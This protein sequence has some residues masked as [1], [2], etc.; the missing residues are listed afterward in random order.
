MVTSMANDVSEFATKKE[1]E[2][3]RDLAKA[4]KHATERAV[5]GDHKFLAYLLE[6]AY[7][8]ANALLEKKRLDKLGRP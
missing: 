1:T 4:I 2:D 5:N 7:L 6:M 8:E 3:L